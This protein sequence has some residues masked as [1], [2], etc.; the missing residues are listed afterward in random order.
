VEESGDVF[1]RAV[2]YD[3]AVSFLEEQMK[4]NLA[5]RGWLETAYYYLGSDYRGSGPSNY[6]L[7][8]MA[9]MGGWAVSDYALYF[10]RDP[11]AYLRL[12]YASFLSSWALVNSGTPESNYGYWYPGHNNDGGAGGGF[13]PR[14]WGRAWLGNKEMGRGSWWYSGEIDLGYSGALRSAATIVVDDP[15]FG[16][17][18]YGGD[19]SSEKNITQ[20]I[21]QDGL[22]ARFHIVR[23]AQRLHI[24]LA[25]DGF[26]KG[27]PVSFDDLLRTIRFTLEN[28][29]A[30]KHDTVVRVRGL[31]AG[32]YEATAQNHPAQKL[33]VQNGEEQ[34][35]RIPVDASEVAV[36]ITRVGGSTHR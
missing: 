7:S 35:I 33:T 21:P 5:C 28:R 2:K 17:F 8:Y 19:L 30:A 4:L 26:R 29:A 14:P 24:L 27:K 1:N 11:I 36:V 25:R 20:V 13:E 9:Q 34:Q 18:A 16:L 3:D 31:P 23:G 22:R 15:I 6:T 10:A 12:G 32:E